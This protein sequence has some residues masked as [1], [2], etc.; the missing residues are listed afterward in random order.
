MKTGDKIRF[1]RITQ[2]K[3]QEEL[4]A[5]I[6]SNSYLSKIEN[7]QALPSDEVLL[8]LSER[9]GISLQSNSEKFLSDISAWYK[10][11]TDRDKVLA[12]SLFD[13]LES[14]IDLLDDSTVLI[15]FTL[16]KFRYYLL[17][18]DTS[19]LHE[20]SQYL[21]KLR[22]LF[23]E[24]MEYYYL[25]F[26]AIYFYSLSQF[27]E[28]HNYLNNAEPFLLKNELEK[29]EE[30]D[31]YFFFGLVASRMY[32]DILSIEYTQRALN[33][34]QADYALERCADCHLLL[35]IAY[36][37]IKE[38]VKSEES[39]LTARKIA[40]SL[41]VENYYKGIIEHNLGNLYSIQGKSCLA[42]K[43]FSKAFTF[44]KHGPINPQL[45]TLYSLVKENYKLKQFN[46][47]EKWLAIGLEKI[48]GLESDYYEFFLHFNV[49]KFE[50]MKEKDSSYEEFMKL[51]V[52][53]FFVNTNDHEHI[54]L[55]SEY[56]GQH[57]E[58]KHFYK[59]AAKYYALSKNALWQLI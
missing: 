52:I 29:W 38:Y 6:I 56:L 18:E 47:V 27:N 53:D 51:K 59:Q 5:G 34:Y 42:I 30:A 10:S 7:N 4:S 26:T 15:Y 40:F 14:Q 17:T 57:F 25:K 50:L 12:S 44:K 45:I 48:N 19:R 9:L 1:F 33:N 22:E 13:E 2:K 35:G 37:N 46:K 31:F 21:M 11:I 16:V 39:Y 8:L 58:N 54:A 3:T 55:Y 43:H 23:N 36:K 32:Q 49:Y 41:K 20:T 24:K 28:A